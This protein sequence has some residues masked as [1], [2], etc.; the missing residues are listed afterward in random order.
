MSDTKRTSRVPS[1]ISIPP[2]TETDAT[3]TKRFEA[4]QKLEGGLLGQ[5]PEPSRLGEGYKALG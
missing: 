2:D 4:T 5:Y 3:F 1:R